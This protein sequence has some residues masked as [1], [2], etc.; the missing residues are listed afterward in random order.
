MKTP[1]VATEIIQPREEE[2]VSQGDCSKGEARDDFHLIL[3]NL[4]GRT[5]W[6]NGRNFFLIKRDFIEI[7]KLFFK[8]TRCHNKMHSPDYI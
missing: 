1:Q 4:K 8:I 5:N 2:D 3:D 6:R 7:Q